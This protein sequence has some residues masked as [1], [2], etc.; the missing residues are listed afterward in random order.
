MNISLRNG[1]MINIEINPLFL[2]YLDD[3]DGGINALV[4]DWKNKENIMYIINFFAYSI[5]ASS[6]DEPIS[7]RE[8]L[9]LITLED[10]SKIS[11]FIANSIPEITKQSNNLNYSKHF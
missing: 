4:N 6:Y 2:E 9:R 5:V 11:D 8:A 7:K 1:K 3:Y 10:L